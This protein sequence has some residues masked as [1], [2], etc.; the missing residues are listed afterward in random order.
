MSNINSAEFAEQMR[1]ALDETKD[2]TEEALKKAVDKT[3]KQTVKAI[4]EKAPVRTGKYKKGWTSKKTTDSARGA[5]G[6]TVYN[7]PKYMIAHLLQNG[8]GG[9]HPARAIPHIPS[10]DE[11]EKLFVDNLESE[12]KG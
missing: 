12:M 11:T 8:H 2:L 5:Y 3:A 4:K 10:D 6:K 1:K 9:K 7:R